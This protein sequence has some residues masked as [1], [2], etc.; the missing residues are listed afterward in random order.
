M[1]HKGYRKII[2]IKKQ[3]SFPFI[4]KV[5]GEEFV[6]VEIPERQGL[7]FSRGKR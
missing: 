5:I 2:V 3:R 1:V 6:E 4:G 7:M